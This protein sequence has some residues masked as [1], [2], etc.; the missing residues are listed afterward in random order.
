MPVDRQAAIEAVL[1]GLQ[2][3]GEQDRR[4][5][6]AWVVDAL[7]PLFEA[8]TVEITD[9]MV[10]RARQAVNAQVEAAIFDFAAEGKPQAE[11]EIV[12]VVLRA[13]LNGGDSE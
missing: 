1:P 7:L 3:W 13:A 9:E 2:A 8:E 6:A 4:D 5:V 12:R 10:E 11:E